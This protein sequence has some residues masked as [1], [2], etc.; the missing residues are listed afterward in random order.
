VAGLLT[1]GD[2][3]RRSKA[4]SMHL[5][6]RRVY[7]RRRLYVSLTTSPQRM[8]GTWREVIPSGYDARDL[9]FK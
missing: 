9:F 8:K 7:G 2:F 4:A 6:S 3:V 5:S 1:G